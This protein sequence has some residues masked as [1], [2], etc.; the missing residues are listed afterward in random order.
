M[1]Y[2]F[3]GKAKR[4]AVGVY[5]SISFAVA[6]EK[7][8]LTKL[9]LIEVNDLSGIKKQEKL[10]KRINSSNTFSVIA[11]EYIKRKKLRAQLA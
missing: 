4:L 5:P 1:K 6:R 8:R 10:N 3:G 11:A 7:T 2:R 9:E